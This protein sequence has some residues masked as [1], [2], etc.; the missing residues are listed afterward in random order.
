LPDGGLCADKFRR[1]LSAPGLITAAAAAFASFAEIL[2]KGHGWCC[3]D[4]LRETAA[5]ANFGSDVV[6]ITA[7]GGRLGTGKLGFAAHN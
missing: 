7:F 4:L 1:D 6:R 2:R 3:L 5:A